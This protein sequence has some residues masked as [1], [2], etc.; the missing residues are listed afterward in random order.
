VVEHDLIVLDYLSDYIHVIFGTPGAYGI[1]SNTK[2]V[3]VGINE[4]LSGF[5]RSENIR[6]RDEIKFEVRHARDKKELRVLISYPRFEKRYNKFRLYV[7]EGEIY[8]P[9]VIGILGPNA[10]G[11]T[12]FVKILAGVENP[13]NTEFNLDII[14]SYKPQYIKPKRSLVRN[15]GIDREFVKKFDL[16]HLMDKNLMDLSGGELQKVAIADCLSRDAGIYLLDEPSAY[17]D[18]EERLK[19]GKLL[20]RFAEDNSKSILVVDHDILLIDYLSDEL[21]VFSGESG[22]RGSASKQLT[23]EKGM[24]LFLKEMN[25]TFRRDLDTRRPRANKPDSVK[26]REQKKLGKYYYT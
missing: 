20:R 7:D 13:D 19:L 12:T 4:Y 3:R 15:L 6:F 24:N 5:L 25:V 23:M 14:V 16:I 26:D 2:S 9:E 8:A 22:L 18:V 21:M 10:T 17:L 11:K 1:V